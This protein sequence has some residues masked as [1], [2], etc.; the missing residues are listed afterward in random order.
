MTPEEKRARLARLLREKARRPRRAPASFSQERMWFLE[1]WNPGS[2]LFNMPVVVRLTGELH[3]EALKRGL[4]HLVD[5]HEA[6]RTTLGVEEGLP[7]QCIAPALEAPL[8]VVEE[9]EARAWERVSVEARRPF[10]VEHGPLSRNV[11]LRLAPDAH[12][13]LVNTHHLVTDAWSLGVLVR[14]LAAV[15]EA[16]V[17]GRPSPLTPLPLQYADYAAWQREWL[18]GPV[19]EEQLSWWCSQLDPTSR[20]ELPTDK[21]R[22][23]VLGSRGER[24][25]RF[26]SPALT[27]SLK[28]LGQREGKT[29]FVVL[30]A[31]F[32]ALLYRYTGQMD[33]TVGSLIA[34]RNRADLE[35]LI[36]LFINALALRTRLTG[37]TSFRELLGA[38]H[39]TTLQ[40][41]ARQDVPFEKVV[42]ALKVQR[43]SSHLPVFQVMLVLQ[44]APLPPLKARGLV[45]DAL[46][47]DTKTTKHDL[48]LYA[49]ELPQ[50]LRLSAEYSTDLFE[51]PTM[52]RLLGHLET[53]LAGAV[54][55]PDRRLAELPVLT[56][57]ERDQLLRD[58][59]GPRAD[60]PRDACIHTLIEAQVRHTPDAVA[61]TF[62]GTSLTYAELDARANQLAWHLR[63][64][65]VGPEVRVGLCLERS[66]EMVVALLATL[67]AG[68][69]YV[70]LDPAYP[71]QRLT[72]MLEDARPA[73]LLAQERLLP[74]LP[75][76][77]ARVVLVDSRWD[78]VAE[79]PR[80]APPP[81]AHPGGLAYVI[82]TSG[83]TGRP[84]G[85]MNEHGP[86]V[87]RL[88]WMQREYGLTAAD[89]VLQ[90]TPFSFDVSVWEFF[91]PLMVGA[92]LVVAKPGGHQEPAYLARLIAEEGVT[93]LHFV[94]SMLQV[95][96][97]EPGLERCASL[98]RVVCSG[99]A[100]PLDLAERCLK[101]L[102]GAGL[103]NLYGPT[104]AAVDVTYYACVP[105]EPRRSVPIGRPVANT[106]IRLLDVNLLPVPI[107]VSG[108]LFIGGVQVGRGYLGRPELT[109]E[110]FIPDPFS[111]TPG[112]RLYRTGDVAR[113]LPD[114]AIEYL[115]R[116]DFQVKVRGL[117]IE[118]GEIEAVLEQHPSVRQA[119]VVARAD[120]GGDKRLVAYVVGRGEAVDPEALRALMQAKLPEYMVPSALMV[121]EALPLSPN[122]KVDRKALPAPELE[123]AREGH[124]APATPTEVEV[125]ALFGEL[126]GVE[127]VGARD[128]L[129]K[130]GGNSLMATR[131]LA[132]LRARFGV[133][134]PL[135]TLF[136]H[137]T[138]QQV[139]RLV[140]EARASVAPVPERAA[141][142]EQRR[143]L[144]VV[145]LR[146]DALPPELDT[147]ASLEAPLT[148]EERHRLLVEW[149][150]TAADFPRE[151]CLHQL[152]EAQA[153]KTPDA[154]A[155]VAGPTRLTYAELEAR[156]NRL[157]WR[158]RSLGV[159]PEV[160]VGLCVE[161][162]A[163]MVVGMLGILKAGGA[164]VPLDPTYPR[165]RL[166]FLLEDA[167][168]PA[169]VAHSHLLSAL[170]P[171]TATAVCL[172]TESL[173]SLPATPPPAP[174]LPE[175]IAYLIY[176]SGSTGRPKGVAI[177]HRAT[178]AFLSWA[179]G[180]FTDDELR[181]VLAG[182]SLNFDLSV[183]E[184]FAPLS[185]GGAV[186]VARDALALA[187]LPHASEVTLVNTVP[188]AMAQLLR[189]GALPASVC[190]V[191]LAGEPLP[192]PLARDVYEVPTVRRLYNLYGPSED[193]TYS[194]F[195]L[196]KAGQPPHIGRPI[197]NTR[198]YV[199]D[200]HLRPVRVGAPGELYLAGQGL[201]RGYLHRPELTAERFLPDP[202][203]PPG[204][205]MYRTGDRVRYRP[206]GELDYLG[207]NDF[208]VKVR[209]FRIEL[210]EVEARLQ[211]LPDV[212]EAV[213]VARDDGPGGQRL[214]AYAAGQGLD[215]DTLREGLRATLPG[216]M[217]PS[218]FVVLDALPRNANGKVDRKALPVP[219]VERASLRPYEAPRTATEEL[220][221]GLWRQV[222]GLERVG[223]KDHFFE[224]GGHSLLAT[225]V[226]ARLRTA[227]R[228]E[229][230]LQAFFEA[231]TLEAL[232]ERVDAA[233]GD[234]EAT[235]VVPPL[236]PV[237]RTANALPVS[238]AQQRLWLLDRLEPGSTAYTILAALRLQGTLN[239]R[240][241][242]LAF[243]ALLAR[244]E[245]LRTVFGEDAQGPTQVILPPGPPD[246][247]LVDLRGLP[248]SEREAEA[249][250]LAEDEA[251]R[252]FDLARGP[253]VRALLARLGEGHHLM[254]VSMHHIISDG[255]SSAVL[256]REL[257]ALYEAFARGEEPRLPPLPAQYADYAVWQRQWLKGEVVESQ[258]GWWKQQ[259]AGAP[260]LLELPTDKPRPEVLS[261]RGGRVPVRLGE[262]VSTALKALC[263]RVGV[264]PFMALLAGFVGLLAHESGQQDVLVGSPVA[265]RGLPELEG[266]IGFFVNT[267]AL[268][269]RLH[270]NPSFRELLGRVREVTLG[271]YAHQDVPFERVVEAVQPQR[272]P[273]R[274]PLFQVMFVLQNAPWAQPMGPG[275]S[276]RFEDVE[277]HSAKFDLTL[278]LWETEEGFSGSLEYASDLFER[279]TAAR[280]AERLRGLLAWAV[281]HPEE[282]LSRLDLAPNVR[283]LLVPFQS[284]GSR[285]PLFCVHA[286]GGTVS[287]YTELV[288]HLGSEHTFIGVQARGLEGEQP[289]LE[290]IEA[291]AALYVE[292]VRTV[293]PQGPYRL[294]GW[295]L[296][297]VI[298]FEMARLL[299]EAGE[300]VEPLILIEPSPT[301]YAQGTRVEESATLE[302]LFALNL[303]RTLGLPVAPEDVQ[304][305]D[306]G[307]ALLKHLLER[308]RRAGVFGPEVGLAR[309]QS[310][311][312]VFISCARAL[313]QHVLRP[314]ALPVILLRGT[315]AEVGEA[316]VPD[317][318]WAALASEVDIVE[319][320]G[321]H[322][323]VLHAPHVETLASAL[324]R[325]LEG[326][327]MRDSAGLEGPPPRNEV[328]GRSRKRTSR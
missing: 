64:L 145:P 153:R 94:P 67:K 268:R 245:S 284:G 170:P 326:S 299:H 70:P 251:R 183:F 106:Q 56:A 41:Y 25:V 293:Q 301:S 252:P 298:A 173:E 280:L 275:L 286:V 269:T 296:G 36:G 187:E 325:V 244:H 122:G 90:K 82:F 281:A 150:D 174:T 231:P 230:P 292:A 116:A 314:L 276:M 2:A 172:D 181:G 306:D 234:T 101:R 11:L 76:H 302:G 198:A 129:F 248:E 44:N 216:Y 57:P 7:V 123:R 250:A 279:T 20:L 111:D 121:L 257:S 5:R 204:S 102:P 75:P 99:E 295:S 282:P 290:S 135:R 264:T 31:A 84:K 218:A 177:P 105:G 219:A 14:E 73:V 60:L 95:F 327:P 18:R 207:R 168:G 175:N 316:H 109:A 272:G 29:L 9:Q 262:P 309:L 167:Q 193:T 239:V 87:N 199:L 188:S 68:G 278:A 133:E 318:G 190:T 85:A 165:E 186:I 180:V 235:P 128:D 247:G 178:V 192:A 152:V 52:A 214:V 182:T 69:A 125:A 288:R 200:E 17:E 149:N 195:S 304:R 161:R 97:E 35:G 81:T 271:A 66:L 104:E 86:V 291:M 93:T 126:L 224:L 322:Y 130:L 210:G 46:P 77:E 103:H 246:M 74:R 283:D 159:G 137:S 65:G 108:E 226:V 266:L 223:V 169:L 91:W 233:R 201:A 24:Q 267:L 13:L 263:H 211:A 236:L 16:F 154:V 30:L 141:T 274:S 1:Q 49:L 113:W 34:G 321:D 61:L 8:E 148:E 176:T 139:A 220:L 185:R 142:P 189:L 300:V 238:F 256:I 143:R 242:V 27:E 311:Q 147:P 289:P 132:R 39:E 221:S 3:L 205:R 92:R 136:Q 155:V 312:R 124:V 287:N 179:H 59:S 294:G 80:H 50:G 42:E 212:R 194:T 26:L 225:Q 324:T 328:G 112:A 79:H 140:D 240:A 134:L 146:A 265:G 89:T 196:V 191:N 285:P 117:R 208:Q 163:D 28:A 228:T 305:M 227:L 4:Q 160:R 209:G 206:T 110:R 253:L 303:A 237:P 203:G 32:K 171:H 38:V 144:P 162:T 37:E 232:A 243:H 71:A 297:G 21:P 119:V 48:T 33:L 88:L 19:L 63:S 72:W 54:E 313:H 317:R 12:L 23:A 98:K 127:R 78:A 83:S 15:Y 156:A 315:E 40:A 270:G 202:F 158:L 255:W 100:L 277:R 184:V 43:D 166:A 157:A 260:S 55:D 249:H 310:L 258:L 308:G 115:G 197:S 53:L 213:V 6:L 107:G 138:V 229:V 120:G 118:L 241:L 254:V 215:A 131:V 58:W 45:M 259:L 114:G 151:L 320:S 164:Y 22:P 62:E 323:T 261:P 51:A 10:D 273:D 307:P 319:V 222:L 217:V 47:V 96:L